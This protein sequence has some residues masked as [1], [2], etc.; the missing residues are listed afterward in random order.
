[1][2]NVRSRPMKN[3]YVAPEL[4]D[5]PED[6]GAPPMP[7]L[8]PRKMAG[9]PPMPA[10]SR[11]APSADAYNRAGVGAA[12]IVGLVLFAALW[13]L[14]GYFTVRTLRGLAGWL[15]VSWLS[16]GVAWVIHMVVSVSEQHAW[17]VRGYAARI[18]ILR[19][20]LLLI[21]V[22]MGAI[23]VVLGSADTLTTVVGLMGFFGA[24]G[25]LSSLLFWT[26][27]AELIAVVPEPVIVALLVLL[28]RLRSS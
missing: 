25:G 12:A 20:F 3:P 28:L 15:S 22:V 2:S 10:R 27:L 13:L 17:K 26:I 18:P 16:W 11:R 9:L 14:N 21:A 1:M 7:A 24:S 6:F 23:A 4:D 5:E 8:P 19:D